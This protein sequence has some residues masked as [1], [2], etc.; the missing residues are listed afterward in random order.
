MLRSPTLRLLA[1]YGSALVV[2]L[3]G[4]TTYDSVR[5]ERESRDQV[6]H[7]RQVIEASLSVPLT[8]LDAETGQR[9][10]LITGDERYLLPYHKS[11]E[12]WQ[13]EAAV[14]RQLTAVN[15]RQQHALDS[16]D[17]LVA[18]KFNELQQ[19]IS[20]RRTR[21]LAAATAVVE[22]GRG[23][24]SMD[25][26]RALLGEI[27]NEERSVLAQRMA[28]EDR[29]GNVVIAIISAGTLVAVI[30]ALLLNGM[31]RRHAEAE[32]QTAEQLRR[33]SALA[34]EARRQAEA[35]NRAKSEFL[36]VMSHELRTPLNAIAGY[37]QLMQMG[38]PEP[39]P[40]SQQDYL[41][42]IQQSQ[43][44][45]LGL[46]NSVLEYARLGAGRLEYHVR[47]VYVRELLA[48]AVPLIEPQALHRKQIV[49]CIPCD[50]ALRLVADEDKALQIV[51]NL[52]S[53]AVKFT[54]PG[55][56]ITVSAER[57]GEGSTAPL[58]LISVA[59][60]GVGIPP[61]KLDAI[62]EAF[63]R[64]EEGR[65]RTTEGTGL[66]LAISRDLARAMGGDLTV[67]S[68]TGEGSMFTFPLPMERGPADDDN[69]GHAMADVAATSAES[70][71]SGALGGDG[72]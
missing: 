69:P 46:I 56:R 8:L 64:V 4:F 13:H 1:S 60:T 30:V 26:I 21:G 59:D 17:T 51:V 22:S 37:V 45:L 34:E 19:T 72:R 33:Q 32:A 20:L 43:R 18:L 68:K 14:L 6:N 9:G 50:P 11:L 54:P 27:E 10:Y 42:R 44:H 28:T 12:S 53:N 63:V 66:G 3:L 57:D 5:R 36:A 35:A 31:L 40:A 38:V 16:L 67:K 55:G 62:F 47:T 52:L 65:T 23:L 48:K 25:A 2:L 71:P 49:R 61:G 24:R 70:E 29:R 58:V 39:V 15:P 7:T 41:A